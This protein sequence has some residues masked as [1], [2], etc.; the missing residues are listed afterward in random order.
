MISLVSCHCKTKLFIDGNLPNFKFTHSRLGRYLLRPELKFTKDK[1]YKKYVHYYSRSF[2]NSD[3]F[4]QKIMNAHIS[5]MFRTSRVKPTASEVLTCY[6]KQSCEPHWTSYFVKY[7]DVV[8]D[9]RGVSHFNWRVG[10][11]NY[12]ILRTGCFPYIKYH[13]SRYP[14]EDLSASNRL[15]Y[16]IKICNLGNFSDNLVST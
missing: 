14:H 13:C 8:N 7:R 1:K 9:Q 5:G 6:L 12:H 15:M 11:S 2:L 16:V 10:N 3:L 4:V